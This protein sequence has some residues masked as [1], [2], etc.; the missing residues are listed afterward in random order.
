MLSKVLDKNT[1]AKCKICCGFAKSDEWEIPYITKSQAKELER[2]GYK[3]KNNGKYYTYDLEFVSDEVK[4]CPYLDF[5]KGCLLSEDEK[6][7]DCKIWPVRLMKKNNEY[8]LAVADICPEFKDKKDDLKKLIDDDLLEKIKDYIKNN[9]YYINELKED[10][11]I[12][13]KVDMGV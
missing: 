13:K 7:F 3:I 2:K 5:K 10:Y 12:I 9:D 1:C 11:T 8:F 6:P 4:Y